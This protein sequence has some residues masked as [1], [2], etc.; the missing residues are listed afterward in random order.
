MQERRTRIVV[1]IGEVDERGAGSAE[2]VEE[3]RRGRV[4]EGGED[5]GAE[6]RAVGG[7]EEGA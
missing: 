1:E 2:E 5:V 4:G 3:C 6:E 7:I